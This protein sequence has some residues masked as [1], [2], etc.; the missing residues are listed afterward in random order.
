LKEIEMNKLRKAT[1]VIGMVIG[2]CAYEIAD[3]RFDGSVPLLCVPIEIS[4]CEAGGKCTNSTVE[5]ANIPQF[6]KV[7]FQDK[8]LASIGE[9]I[10]TAAIAHLDRES[11]KLILHGGQ[12]GRGWTVLISEATGKMAATISEE[13]AAFVIF[14]ACAPL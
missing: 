3:A 12:K 2:V 1:S 11:G 13:R 7:N 10:R 4:E 5:Q 9:P 8:T 14:G 6:I